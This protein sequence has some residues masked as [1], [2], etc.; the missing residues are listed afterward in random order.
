MPS[1]SSG[2]IA[3]A[4]CRHRHDR[5]TGW[6]MDDSSTSIDA[7]EYPAASRGAELLAMLDG[8]AIS[9][10]QRLSGLEV[11]VI[12]ELTA[13]DLLA[14]ADG[15]VVSGPTSLTT[16]RA[17]HHRIAQLLASEGA[18]PARVSLVTG[19]SPAYVR[20]LQGDPVFRELLAY[21][22]NQTEAVTG[23][24]RDRLNTLGLSAMDELQM[25]LE[26]KPDEFTKKDLMEIVKQ[27]TPAVGGAG[28]SALGQGPQVSLNV[29]FVQAGPQT[30][31]EP[32]PVI[33]SQINRVPPEQE[34]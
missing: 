15:Q 13:E 12:R 18:S 19:Y 7:S 28:S 26:E 25:R 29:Q 27:A 5:R 30:G 20:R 8:Q 17:A 10:P 16:I 34:I 23:D 9:S 32:M 33:N 24:L 22:A 1:A 6:L 4:Q 3:Q 21:Y 11:T 31:V 2:P 14:C